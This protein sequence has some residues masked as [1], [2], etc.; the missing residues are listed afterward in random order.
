MNNQSPWQT[1]M[2]VLYDMVNHWQ[3]EFLQKQSVYKNMALSY[4]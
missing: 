2:Q 1:Y 3:G 4:F